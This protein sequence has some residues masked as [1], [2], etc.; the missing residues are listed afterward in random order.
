V[1]QLPI[2]TGWSR[3]YD[4][5]T[6][7]VDICSIV[8]LSVQVPVGFPILGNSITILRAILCYLA[9][10][11]FRHYRHKSKGLK[12]AMNDVAD[13]MSKNAKNIDSLSPVRNLENLH[14]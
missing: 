2:P 14:R 3:K 6:V 8:V 4:T 5:H 9:V 1:T 11:K 12:H 7:F 13:N 10:Q